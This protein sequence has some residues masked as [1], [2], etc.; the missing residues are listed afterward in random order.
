MLWRSYWEQVG[1]IPWYH[2]ANINGCTI[3]F[4]VDRNCLGGSVL[5]Y[6]REGILIKL[7]SAE[8][9]EGLSVELNVRKRK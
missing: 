5:T 2:L 1:L 6:V 3:L 7:N 9:I 4:K 8:K